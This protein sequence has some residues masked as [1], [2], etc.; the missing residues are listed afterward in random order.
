LDKLVP[1]FKEALL[2]MPVG[3][4]WEIYIP[5][6]LGYGDIAKTKI[7]PASTLIFEV[8]LVDTKPAV[9]KPAQPGKKEIKISR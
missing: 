7:P 4:K 2:Q 6:P 1:G 9:A 3:S 8:E 5:A